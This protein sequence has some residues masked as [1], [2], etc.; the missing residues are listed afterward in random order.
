M[1]GFEGSI[2]VPN[3]ASAVVASIPRPQVTSAVQ[4]A[5]VV[6]SEP[7]V[8]ANAQSSVS[9]MSKAATLHKLESLKQDERNFGALRVAAAE[10]NDAVK[11]KA[12]DLSFSVDEPSKRFVVEVKDSKTG[13]LIRHIPGEAVLRTA[14]TLDA[15]KGLLFDDVY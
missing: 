1:A 7:D 8:N 5:S 12:I 4:V 15:L 14:A 6:S 2:K 3:P 13:Q 10:L 11:T 9:V